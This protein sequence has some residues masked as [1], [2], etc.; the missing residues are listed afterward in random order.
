[1][2]KFSV[3]CYITFVFQSSNWIYSEKSKEC[4]D[5]SCY[6]RRRDYV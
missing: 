4:W 2:T 3:Y 1:M 6:D 5:Y